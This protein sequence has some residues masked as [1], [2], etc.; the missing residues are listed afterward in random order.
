MRKAGAVIAAALVLSA[1]SYKA[2]VLETPSY[3][4]VSSYGGELPGLWLLY[5]DAAPLRRPIKPS[6][7]ACSFHN[8]PIDAA[9]PFATSVRQTLDNVVAN[10]EVVESPVSAD[11]IR[12]RGARGMIVVR[13]EEVR[14]SIDV[15]PGFWSAAMESRATVIASISVDGSG[16]RLFGQTVEGTGTATSEA[17]M[18]CS[19]GAKS[20]GQAVNQ[21]MGDTMRKLGEALANS[22]RVRGA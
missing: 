13:G 22:E 10:I 4:V 15:K 2:E 7:Y 11:K 20:L 8:Y 1:C 6:S 18:A 9:G 5:I 17:G 21:G 16:G 19:G 14:A 3:N 12:A